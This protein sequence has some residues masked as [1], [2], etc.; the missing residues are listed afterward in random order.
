MANF[1]K[2]NFSVSFNPTSAFPLD[3]R[4]YFESYEAAEAAAKQA[5]PVGSSESVYYYGQTLV[6]VEN[7]A[8]ILYTIQPDNTLKTVEGGGDG[9]TSDHRVLSNRDA[10][11]AHPISAITGLKSEL[12]AK[13]AASDAL[14]NLE[15]QNIIG[16]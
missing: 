11:D 1:G 15:I 13:V 3:A 6:V 2:L 12:S 10:D 16:G 7:G 4:S 9:G 8:A 14:T 5:K